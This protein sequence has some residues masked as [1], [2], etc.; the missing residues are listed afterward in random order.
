MSLWPV[1]DRATALLMERFYRNL[2]TGTRDPAEALRAAQQEVRTIE[3]LE[4]PRHW[5]AFVAFGRPA[6]W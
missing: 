3:G 2:N 5:A 1:R 6:V 4:H